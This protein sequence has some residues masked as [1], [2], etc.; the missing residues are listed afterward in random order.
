MTPLGEEDH[1]SRRV[2]VVGGSCL[3]ALGMGVAFPTTSV[4]VTAGMQPH[5]RGLAGGLF[6]TS[7]Q[8][9][10]AIGLGILATIAAARTNAA[11]G[12]LVSGYRITYLISVGIVIIAATTTLIQLRNR[13][14][15]DISIPTTL[16]PEA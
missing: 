9:G 2:V 1:P 6:A 3:T 5:E 10:Q 4:A 12:T 15:A 8:V 7:Q 16:T 11:H 13:H 14:P